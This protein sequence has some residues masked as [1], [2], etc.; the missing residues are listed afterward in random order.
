MLTANQAINIIESSRAAIYTRYGEHPGQR[1]T[2]VGLA[3]LALCSIF[4]G[5]VYSQD[6]LVQ[7][8]KAA[9]K[10]IAGVLDSK[11]LVV[12]I[13]TQNKPISVNVQS[14][15]PKD[16]IQK[17]LILK[18]AMKVIEVLFK[19]QDCRMIE[20]YNIQFD[21]SEKES[22]VAVIQLSRSIAENVEWQNMNDERFEALLEKHGK[23][24]LAKRAAKTATQIRKEQIEQQFSNWDGSHFGLTR[25]IK[26]T[27]NDP[28][29]YEHIKTVYVDKGDYLIVRTT[30]RG[31]N[32]LGALVVNSVTARVD[33]DGN[34]I[35]II[36]QEP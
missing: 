4:S 10:V 12:T 21:A 27:M 30:F 28:S 22:G 33:L 11:S 15:L 25:L 35:E 2:Y 26:K 14:T 3:F 32:K 6:Q 5:A 36:S 16:E 20:V 8:E 29:S 31:K 7:T 23:I 18:L 1:I 34:V 24:Q 17:E 9:K 13:S 19:S